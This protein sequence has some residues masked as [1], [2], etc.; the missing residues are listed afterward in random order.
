[1]DISGCYVFYEMVDMC[2][3]NDFQSYKTGEK[4]HCCGQLSGILHIALLHI[5]CIYVRGFVVVI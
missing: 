4:R 5:T 1:M 2:L 3:R